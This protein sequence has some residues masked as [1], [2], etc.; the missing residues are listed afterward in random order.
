MLELER[1]VEA[2]AQHA[3]AGDGICHHA[4]GHHVGQHLPVAVQDAPPVDAVGGV[5]LAPIMGLH[6]GH[7]LGSKEPRELPGRLVQQYGGEQ[8]DQQDQGF[9]SPA[10]AVLAEKR[11]ENGADHQDNGVDQNQEINQFGQSKTCPGSP[12]NHEP[13]QRR[14]NFHPPG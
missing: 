11:L 10:V 1:R 8:Q 14:N 13:Q 2:D 7:E 12:Q 9:A 4:G 3:V 6:E 5:E